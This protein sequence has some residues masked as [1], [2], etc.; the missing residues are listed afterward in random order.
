MPHAPA[1]RFREAFG[2]AV[3][4]FERQPDRTGNGTGGLLTGEFGPG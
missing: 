2:D 3:S 4:S 1:V